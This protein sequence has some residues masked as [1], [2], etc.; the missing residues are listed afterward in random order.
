MAA[1]QQNNNRRSLRQTIGLIAGPLVALVLLIFFDLDP[2]NPLVTRAAAVAALMAIW[3]ITE[4]IPIPATAL[5]P[6]ALFP[7]LGIMPG[8]TVAATYFN[9]IIFLF[10]GGFI[11]ALAMQKWNLHRRI[12]LKIILL[13]G[14]SPR[15][16]VLGFMAATAFLSMWISNTATTMM[17]VPIAMAIIV[18]LKENFAGKET[19][20]FSVGLLI[21]IA[22]AASIGGT[23]TLIG[24]PPNLSFTRIFS[25]YFPEAPEI[26]FAQ[27]I[28]FGLPLAVL[29]LLIAWRLLTWIFVPGKK[30]FAADVNIFREEYR[31]LGRMSYEERVVL[32][33][34]ILLAFLWLFRTDIITGW[35]VIP[36]WSGIFPMP[37][38]IDD[39]TVAMMIA[40]LLFV[41][42]ARSR[43]GTTRLGQVAS[44]LMD[45]QTA[46][47][48]H[49]GIVILFGGGFALASGFKESGLSVWFGQQLTG[50]GDTPPVLMI[51]SICTMLTFL[52]ELTSNTATTEMV[53]P[54]LG[55]LAVAIKTNPLLLMIPATL[56]ASCAFMLPV[57]TPPNAIVFGTGEVRMAD[58]MRVG[59]IM[60]LI[61]VVL[62]TAFIY[63]LGT[64]VFSIDPGQ[65]PNWAAQP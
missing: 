63:L 49:W 45:W 55:S 59:I 52:T 30:A 54:L 14:V 53:L 37:G 64:A 20:R 35:F 62:I 31:R 6:V 17:M 60:N 36:G 65:M 33:L 47:K 10:I 42:P 28:M 19:S 50:L 43:V 1:N 23:A 25:I 7:L 12:A 26:S 8:K 2:A 34:F 29:F 39:G 18:K 40:A 3:W 56:S 46:G 41:I 51:G 21:A 4:A 9:H 38:F 22:Y 5:L 44:R 61:G 48:L 58:M 16:I 27:W 57:A 32:I 11:M 24:T 13:I 15:R